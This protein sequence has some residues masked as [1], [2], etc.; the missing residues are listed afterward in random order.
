MIDENIF[1]SISAQDLSVGDMIEWSR[2]NSKKKEWDMHYG[3]ITNVSN[4]IRSNRLVSI[5][6][7]FPLSNTSIELEFFTLSLR[8]ISPGLKK[9]FNNDIKN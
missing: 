3:I 8:L 1:G 5:C 7:V 2:W 6:K 9:E 4:E